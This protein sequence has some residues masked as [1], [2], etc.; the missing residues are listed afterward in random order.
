MLP[1]FLACV[2]AKSGEKFLIFLFNLEFQVVQAPWRTLLRAI[3][4]RECQ[5][6]VDDTCCCQIVQGCISCSVRMA[7]ARS[8]QMYCT[9]KILFFSVSFRVD[10]QKSD[11]ESSLVLRNESFCYKVGTLS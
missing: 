3:L 5:A 8:N 9:V 11:V 4:S 2:V 1:G 10:T 6:D 7:E